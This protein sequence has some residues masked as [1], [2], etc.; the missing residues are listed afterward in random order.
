MPVDMPPHLAEELLA[1]APTIAVNADMVCQLF[2]DL[3][4]GVGLRREGAVLPSNVSAIDVVL[5]HIIF[6]VRAVLLR[7]KR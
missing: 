4:N 6:P 2:D 3:F 1:E 5:A 7:P